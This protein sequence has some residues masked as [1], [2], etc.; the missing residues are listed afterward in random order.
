VE[1]RLAFR[2]A[3]KVVQ[4]QVELGQRVRAGQVLAQLDAQ[5]YRLS[6]DASRAQLAGAATNRDLA[7]ADFKRF[8][9]LREQNFIS[10]AE[11]ERRE[12]TLKSAQAQFDAAQAQL[13]G[14]SNQAAYTSLVADV[15]G[16][17]TAVEVEVGQVVAAGTPV[18]RIA[19]D[20]PR[21]VMFS[22]PEDKVAMIRVG[23][24]ASVMPWSSAESLPATVREVASSA[25]PVT[26][27]FA[28][29]LAMDPKY[30]LPLGTTVTVRANNFD[31]S[32]TQAIRI[33]TSA[34]LREADSTAVWVL[35]A[36]SMV[37]NLQR[38][39]VLTADGNMAV[40]GAGLKPGMQIVAAGVH[41]LSPGQKVTVYQDQN[42]A[43]T[44]AAQ[45]G[46]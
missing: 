41:V 24:G 29:K 15:A 8:K 33:P 14:L 27:T 39:E 13:A 9:E 5:D 26:R 38:I 44:P 43:A 25:D 31:H 32:G 36:A 12:A 19:K 45:A 10:S 7:Q 20:G 1:S 18:F 40:V 16:V 22:V 3:G 17:V 21:D 6:V 4:R 2:V 28:V 35:D 23:S 42:T 46:K 37:V 11:L 34:L 30:S